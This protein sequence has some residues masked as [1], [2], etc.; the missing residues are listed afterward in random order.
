M[1]RTTRANDVPEEDE[2]AAIKRGGDGRTGFLYRDSNSRLSRCGRTGSMV[3][4]GLFTQLGVDDTRDDLP[5]NRESFSS[6][7]LCSYLRLT[8]SH[9]TSSWKRK[10]LSRYYST[11]QYIDLVSSSQYDM[12]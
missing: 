5:D 6:P 3:A 7:F 10:V 1:G 9:E 12:L 2:S 11:V 4:N 8:A